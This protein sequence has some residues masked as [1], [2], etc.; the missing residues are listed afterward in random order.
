MIDSFNNDFKPL[1]EDL[2]EDVYISIDLDVLGGKDTIPTGYPEGPL[3]LNMLLEC[4]ELVKKYRNLISADAVGYF[5]SYQTQDNLK[6]LHTYAEIAKKIVNS[7]S[8]KI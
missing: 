3:S 6:A 8:R 2:P 7:N 1:L 5:P 4:L